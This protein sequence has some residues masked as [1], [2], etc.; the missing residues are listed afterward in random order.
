MDASHFFHFLPCFPSPSLS[1]HFCSI[2]S[3]LALFHFVF[4][5][6]S[7][8][9]LCLCFFALPNK[10]SSRRHEAKLRFIESNMCLTFSTGTP[11]P[12]LS[13]LFKTACEIRLINRAA[14]IGT[15]T[16]R[17]GPPLVGDGH[18]TQSMHPFSPFSFRLGARTVALVS[19]TVSPVFHCTR[20]S[21]FSKK[22][23]ALGRTLLSLS[24]HTSRALFI[25]TRRVKNSLFVLLRSPAY[26][27]FFLCRTKSPQRSNSVPDEN[28]SAT[29][30]FCLDFLLPK[31]GSNRPPQSHIYISVDSSAS[32]AALLHLLHT[33]HLSCKESC[34][35]SP[36][37]L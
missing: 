13:P 30:S 9:D 24:S 34:G 36:G 5:T 29:S 16:T 22:L 17:G 18:M 26:F 33:E 3:A 37:I 1:F 15:Y 2:S 14:F 8:L 21:G 20:K 25:S 12:P 10:V 28:T 35:A 27:F 11:P 4:I 7:W 31:N 32:G 23:H 6:L 19:K